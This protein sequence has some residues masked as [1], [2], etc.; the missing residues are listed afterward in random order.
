MSEKKPTLHSFRNQDWRTVKF[1]T[2]KVNDLLTNIPTND[3]TELK[4]WSKI[5]LGKNRGPLEDHR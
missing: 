3:K 5:S 4:D 2:E 1:E